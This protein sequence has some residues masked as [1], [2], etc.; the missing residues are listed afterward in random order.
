MA[1][2]RARS[3]RVWAHEN[4]PGVFLPGVGAGGLESGYVGVS[5]VDD[6]V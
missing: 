1:A 2:G 3:R 5:A 4:T 6:D